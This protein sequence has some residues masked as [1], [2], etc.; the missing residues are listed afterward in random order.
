MPTTL[1]N[2]VIISGRIYF[3]LSV[4]VLSRWSIVNTKQVNQRNLNKINHSTG[5]TNSLVGDFGNSLFFDENVILCV[6]TWNIKKCFLVSLKVSKS[7]QQPKQT[8]AL[9]KTYK[10]CVNVICNGEKWLKVAEN[11]T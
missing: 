3:A 2:I 10:F 8:H 7:Q 1:G 11:S 6:T 5:Q 4:L 9:K